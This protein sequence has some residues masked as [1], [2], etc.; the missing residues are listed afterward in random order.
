[1]RFIA[2][3]LLLNSVIQAQSFRIPQSE[4][5]LTL[6][7]LQ[8]SFD[9]WA[10]T[11]DLKNTRHW[12]YISRR[13]N[14]WETRTDGSGNPG[15]PQELFRYRAQRSAKKSSAFEGLWTPYGPDYVPENFTGYAENGIGRINCIA[16]HPANSQIFWVGVAQGGLWKTEDGGQNWIPLTDNLPLTRVSDIAVNPSNPDEIYISLCD[17]EYIGIGLA[18]DN[19]YR[20]AHYGMGVFKTIDGGQSWEQTSLQF[21]VTDADASLIR[22]ILVH[23]EQTNQVLACGVS[24]MYRSDDSGQNWTQVLDTLF[25][26]L[27]QDPLQPNIVYA[28]SGWL[29]SSNQGYASVYKSPDFGQTWVELN[30]GIP[31]TGVVQ[32]IKLAISESNPDIL[33]AI[34]VDPESGL[35]SLYKSLNAGE[36]WFELPQLLNILEGGQGQNPGGQGTYD[37]VLHVDKDNSD[38]VYAGGVNLY[39]SSNGGVSF[40]PVSHW[41]LYYGETVHAD[42]HFF[43]QHPL[44]DEYFICNDGG[45]YKTSLIISQNWDDANNGIPWPSQWTNLGDGMQISSFYRV[46][47]SKLNDDRVIAGAQ[48]NATMYY[49]GF[50]WRSIFGGDGM[51]CLLNPFDDQNIIG[52]AQYGVIF[53]TGDGANQ[54]FNVFTADDA[55]EVAEWTTPITGCITQSNDFLMFTGFQSVF[56][57]FDWGVFWEPLGTPDFSGQPL[58]S[59][60]VFGSNCDQ[61]IA[62]SRINYFENVQSKVYSSVDGGFAWLDITNGLPDSLY[63]TSVAVNR[64]NSSEIVLTLGGF[65]DGIKVFRT[66]NAGQSWQNISFNLPNFPVNRAVYLPSGGNLLLATDAGVFLLEEGS[67]E[68]S[69]QSAGLPNVIVSD[70]DINVASNRVYISTFGRGIWASELGDITSVK[71]VECDSGIQFRTLGNKAFGITLPENFCGSPSVDVFKSL[72]IID[73][74]GRQVMSVPVN[75]SNINFGLPAGCA[76]GLYFARLSGPN[77]SLVHK[78]Y[79]Q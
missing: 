32:R 49:D 43:T 68:W 44:T 56:A 26:D 8:H 22:K 51:D 73:V 45:L 62:T 25:W 76:S 75:Q 12:K 74:M 71:N 50:G 78:F 79:A 57:S 77:R 2:I 6:P 54:D 9:S 46:S 39:M 41:T 33:Y 42:Q 36:S 69:D 38:F 13:L 18:L 47:S 58:T 23:P 72:E 15:N 28:A 31:N 20:F 61:L 65:V 16:F 3:I 10:D 67:A 30:T 19:R 37:L 60:D 35:E 27:V 1:M 64:S 14:E 5:G 21:D 40:D 66:T 59:L 34:T 7:E 53:Q 17:F 48:D 63:Y 11:A 70:I 55:F 29:L 24:G 52:A 4:N